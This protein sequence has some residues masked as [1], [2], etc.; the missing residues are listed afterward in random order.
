M[1]PRTK[2]GESRQGLI[3]TLVIFV[4][5][6]ICF[7][8]S[9]YYGFADQDAKDKAKKE[10]EQGKKVVED[11]RNYYKA[12]A[13]VY[14][15]HM[16][17]TEGMADAENIGTYKKQLDDG[18][19]GKNSKDYADVKKVLEG[20][21]KQNKGWNGNQPQTTLD[22]TIKALNAQN[23][24]LSTQLAKTQKDRDALNKEKQKLV[25]ELDAAREDYKKNL[26]KNAAAYKKDFEK[27]DEE[28]K[29]LRDSFDRL[30]QERQ[31]EKEEGSQA[32]EASAKT[33]SRR[34]K[35]ISDLKNLVQRKQEE[36]EQFRAKNPE[37]PPNMRTDWKI[38]RMDARGTHPYINLGSADHVRPQLTF[39]VYSL[40]SDGRPYPQPKGTLE[41]VSVLSAHLSQ[42]R[43]TS[44][45]DRNRDPIVEGDVIYNGSWNPNIRK[46]IAIAGIID[47]TGDGRDSLNEFIRNL[48]RQNIIVDAWEDPKDG[49]IK[50]QGMSYQTDYLVLGP[51]PDASASGKQGEAAKRVLDGRKQI[52][53]EAKKYGVP[54]KNL[55]S[56]LEMIGYPLPHTVREAGPPSRYGNDT[57]TRSDI[58]PRLGRDKIVPKN[59]VKEQPQ[60]EMPPDK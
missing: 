41:V 53:D 26:D 40:G 25:A 45:K 21:D 35:E 51:A 60:G 46:H 32:K 50:G 18:T 57:D 19:L 56:Y 9:T 2:S 13:L 8:V 15:A 14:R 31:K 55:I 42:A 52:Q 24:N 47:L 4:L 28:F 5:A 59:P 22:G 16:G 27:L 48:E 34:E 1:P 17:L 44:V 23:E 12:Q 38:I 37:A 6:T 10:A 49:T 54:V 33:V 20:L 11:D 58:V 39:S 36:V 3:I 43:I 7:G 30:S 29:S